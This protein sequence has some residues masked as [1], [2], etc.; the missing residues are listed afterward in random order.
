V[1]EGE[2]SEYLGEFILLYR[3]FVEQKLVRN[4]ADLK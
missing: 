2:K 3:Q 4:E 1:Q